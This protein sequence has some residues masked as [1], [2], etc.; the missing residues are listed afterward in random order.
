MIA[1]LEN[2]GPDEKI[3]FRE[4][5]ETAN[6]SA[7]FNRIVFDVSGTIAPT[8][9]LPEINDPVGGTQISG[10]GRITL[11]GRWLPS[12]IRKG[13]LA[14]SSAHN[15]I[16]GINI[17][18]FPEY[19]ICIRG[20]SA[21]QNTV[22]GCR[23]GT[24]GQ[25]M[26]GNALGITLCEGASG[27]I[28]GGSTVEEGNLISANST[29]GITLTGE[30]VENNQIIGNCIGLNAA[31]TGSLPNGR[32]GILITNHAA[33]NYIGGTLAAMGNVIAGNNANGIAISYSAN[34]NVIQGNFIGCRTD[35][36]MGLG[37]TQAG[38]AVMDD[39]YAN[40]IGG[41]TEDTGN[42][43]AG[44][45]TYGIT[46]Y[47]SGSFASLPV[48][49]E[50]RRN[51]I[52]K[53]SLSAINLADQ[54][55]EAIR[56][57]GLILF[58]TLRGVARSASII[59]F[60]ASDAPTDSAAYI[61]SAN[62]DA[63]GLFSFFIDSTLYAGKYITAT[64][65]DPNGNTSALSRAILLPQSNEGEGEDEGEGSAEGEGEGDGEGNLEGE[66]EGSTSVD[67]HS[68]DQ[69]RDT[70]INLSELLRIIQFYNSGGYYCAYVTED[71]YAP[72]ASGSY[73]CDYHDGDYAPSNWRIDLNELLR[74][75][76]F[77][78]SAQIHPCETGEDG[79]CLG[80]AFSD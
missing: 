46:L 7:G 14:I 67:Y 31:Q 12:S 49:I 24:R 4:A 75:I 26:Q 40:L 63:D 78:N 70:Y 18:S 19:G 76:Q 28:I 54:A 80:A 57:P 56:P 11:D 42:L 30:G 36:Q 23:I 62:S 71:G 58:D 51:R 43:I 77:Y 17:C 52:Y 45:A 10:E 5:L 65:T 21:T 73:L 53:N 64:A 59:D 55:N 37:N 33:Y 3:S 60:F 32:D 16:E 69:N 20:E 29:W 44:N 6:N 50:M 22:R 27:N 79:F 74:I 72:G 35:G 68:A 39:A 48:Q 2:P 8:S 47:T 9:T 38:I 34:N 15:T 61:G 41:A 1:L 66:G 13:A 25:E